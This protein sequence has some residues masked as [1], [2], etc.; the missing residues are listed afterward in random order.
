MELHYIIKEI[1]SKYR[2]KWEQVRWVGFT[3]ARAMTGTPS[4]PSELLPFSWDE[5]DS[6]DSKSNAPVVDL[7]ETA[8]ELG[9]FLDRIKDKI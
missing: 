8:K 3:T 1:N 9:N 6:K 5:M 7:K 4:K 2:N